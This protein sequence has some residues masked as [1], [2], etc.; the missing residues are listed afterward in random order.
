MKESQ[1]NIRIF[2]KDIADNIPRTERFTQGITF[3]Q[4]RDDE[5][6]YYATVQCIEIIG[7]A[8][9]HI[10]PHCGPGTRRFPGTI[11]QACGTS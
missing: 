3:E 10:P 2:L 1:R 7:E 6:T 11:W 9:K 4:F 5:K 8:A